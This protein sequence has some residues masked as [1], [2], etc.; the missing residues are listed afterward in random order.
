MA[1]IYTARHRVYAHL[2]DAVHRRK[3][4]FF[5]FSFFTLY[6]HFRVNLG[7]LTWVR[8]QQPQEQ[9]FPVLEEHAGSFR[10]SVRSTPISDNHGLQDL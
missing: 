7:R 6:Y 4:V 3:L 5:S 1:N 10:V 8:L 9:R 2:Q